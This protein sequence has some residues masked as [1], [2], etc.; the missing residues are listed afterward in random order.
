MWRFTAE[1]SAEDSVKN[2]SHPAVHKKILLREI[3]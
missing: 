2:A 1:H 3:L